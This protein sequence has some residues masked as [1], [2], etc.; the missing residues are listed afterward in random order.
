MDS[1]SKSWSNVRGYGKLNIYEF[2]ENKINMTIYDTNKIDKLQAPYTT[3][4]D[5]NMAWSNKE[6]EC[7]KYSNK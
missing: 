4:V 7:L 1:Q 6:L 2:N 3:L 5:A